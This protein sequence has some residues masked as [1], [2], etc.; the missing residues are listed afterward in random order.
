M[1]DQNLILP[2]WKARLAA[3]WVTLVFLAYLGTIF[4]E[5]GERIGRIVSQWMD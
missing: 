3:V 5:R 1:D 2:A 4:V